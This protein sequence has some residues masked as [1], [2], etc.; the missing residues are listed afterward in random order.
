MAPKKLMFL[1]ICIHV[2]AYEMMLI[3]SS[4]RVKARQGDIGHFSVAVITVTCVT[5]TVIAI[6][7][8]E[9]IT[10]H[11]AESRNHNLKK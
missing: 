7:Q 11:D 2:H 8:S 9:G 10:M 5:K 4:L 3:P 6:H 1:F